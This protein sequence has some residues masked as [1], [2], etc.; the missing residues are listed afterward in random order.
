M[1]NADEMKPGPDE[2]AIENADDGDDMEEAIAK[3]GTTPERIA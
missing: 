3:T 1:N 2:G